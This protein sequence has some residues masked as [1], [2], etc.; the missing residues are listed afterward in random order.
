MTFCGDASAWSKVALIVILVALGLHSGGYGT[1]YWMA[2]Y[3]VRDTLNFGV[4]LWRVTNCSGSYGAPC[5]DSDVPSVYI[6]SNMQ[7]TRAL[8][9]VALGLLFVTTVCLVFYVGTE[10]SRTRGMAIAI[11]MLALFAALS[12]IAGMVVWII[13]LPEYHYPN[14]SMGLTVFAITLSITSAIL[15]VPDIRQYDYKDNLKVGGEFRNLSVTEA[16]KISKKQPEPEPVVEGEVDLKPKIIPQH[17]L[18]APSYQ[19]MQY[20]KRKLYDGF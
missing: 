6:T 15:L 4:G 7:A 13:D 1:N 5:T 14:W 3:T 17:P 18:A 11:M 19:F 12:S 9:G 2:R 10:R 16:A 20:N 8:E